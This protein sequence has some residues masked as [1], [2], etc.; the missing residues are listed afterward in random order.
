MKTITKKL[1]IVSLFFSIAAIAIADRGI[2]KKN[3][4]KT[5]LNIATNSSSIRNSIAFN[6]KSGLTY[7]GSLISSTSTVGSSLISNSVIT[8]QK[9]NMTYIIP[10]K[11]KIILADIKQG[12]TGMKLIIRPY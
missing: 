6:L 5:T 3:K 11:H 8:Y 12:Y 10:Y 1:L 7:K 2:G 4:N 9:G